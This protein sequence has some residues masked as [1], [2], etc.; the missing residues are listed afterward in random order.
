MTEPTLTD[1]RLKRLNVLTVILIALGVIAF[2]L[3]NWW[4]A[5]DEFPHEPPISA[6]ITTALPLIIGY[7]LLKR[8]KLARFAAIITG[9]IAIL[10]LLPISILS[11]DSRYN[12]LN[13]LDGMT[14]RNPSYCDLQSRKSPVGYVVCPMVVEKVN[15]PHASLT[16]LSPIYIPTLIYLLILL[17][18]RDVKV[19]FGV[20]VN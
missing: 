2:I 14:H 18:R 6:L 1:K 4:T 17:N 20:G 9:A 13:A 7:G 16:I 12:L 5:G 19:A 3:L 15:Y 8:K 11:I 10:L